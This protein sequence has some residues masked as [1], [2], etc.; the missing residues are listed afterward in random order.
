MGPYDR[1]EVSHDYET[2]FGGQ[3]EHDDEGDEHEDH[4]E[5]TD[6]DDDDDEDNESAC[7]RDSAT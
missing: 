6:E 1:K 3:Y 7:I 2:T 4:D 5:H